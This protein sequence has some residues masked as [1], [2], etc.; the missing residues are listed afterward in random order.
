MIFRNFDNFQIFFSIFSEP[1]FKKWPL[2][3]LISEKFPKFLEKNIFGVKNCQIW[4]V[5]YMEKIE[6]MN[7][8]VANKTVSIEWGGSGGWGG[9]AGRGGWQKYKSNTSFFPYF[10]WN[11]KLFQQNFF[12]FLFLKIWK[13]LQKISSFFIIFWQ[14]YNFFKKFLNFFKFSADFAFFF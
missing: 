7:L 5:L 6:K 10:S 13:L 14:F 4:C 11:L 1:N 12:I 2:E 3:T 9:A 8:Y